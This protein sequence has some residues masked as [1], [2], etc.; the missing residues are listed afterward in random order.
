MVDARSVTRSRSRSQAIGRGIAAALALSFLTAGL[1]PDVSRTGMIVGGI[2]LWSESLV[3]AAA[4]TAAYWPLPSRPPRVLRFLTDNLLWV[5]AAS[6]ALGLLVLLPFTPK[7]GGDLLAVVMAIV[8]LL[9]WSLS[10]RSR[11]AR[12]RRT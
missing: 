9:L 2:V 10:R 1:W 12:A 3:V 8:V 6:F 11:S 4:V 5:V 7:Y